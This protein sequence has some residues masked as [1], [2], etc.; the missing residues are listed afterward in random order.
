MVEINQRKQASS[1][2]QRTTEDEKKNRIAVAG[3]V[4]AAAAAAFAV[5]KH[6]LREQKYKNMQTFVLRAENGTEAHIRPL[7]CCIQRMSFS[8]GIA[9]SGR[10]QLDFHKGTILRRFACA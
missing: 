6:F 1:G 3:A 9:R 8:A 2:T 5:G 10:T 4:I 7:G